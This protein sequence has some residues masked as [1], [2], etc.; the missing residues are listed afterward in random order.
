MTESALR[1]DDLFV[2]E[3][4]RSRGIGGELM[5]SLARVARERGCSRIEWT[6]AL[7]NERGIAFYER[8]EATIS[9]GARLVHL[10]PAGIERPANGSD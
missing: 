4:H 9:H 8:H 6:V 5:T 1:L 2:R 7:R 3:E 10:T